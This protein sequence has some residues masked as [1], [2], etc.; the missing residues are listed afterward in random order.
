MEQCDVLYKISCLNCDSSYIGQIKRKVK[1][2]IKEHKANIKKPEDSL[3][4]YTASDRMWSQNKL[5]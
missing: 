1:T 5:G 4:I 2:R 3:T